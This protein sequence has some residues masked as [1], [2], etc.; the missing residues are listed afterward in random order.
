MR[1]ITAVIL[2]P[3]S[4]LALA[5]ALAAFGSS[6]GEEPAAGPDATR[7]PGDRRA[8]PAADRIAALVDG[9]PI[10]VDDVQGLVDEADGGVS[11][12]EALDALV[13]QQLLAAEAERRGFGAD[14]E[15][16]AERRKALARA[17]VELQADGVTVDTLDQEKLRKLYESSIDQFVHGPER[18]VI[19]AVALTGK[20]RLTDEEA[21]RLIG[22]V[23]DAARG[24][25][26]EERFRAAVR[27]LIA[28]RGKKVLKV[29]KLPPFHAASKRFAGPFVEAAFAVPGPGH[30]SEPFRTEFGW[31]VLLVLEEL[32]AADVSYEEAREIIGAEVVPAERKQRIDGLLDRLVE[33]GGVVVHEDSPIAEAGAQ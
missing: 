6:C 27:P 14:D 16:D 2:R 26:T 15:V 4:Q 10:T 12:A 1:T 28:E 7:R 21:R 22:Q 8:T 5:V 18:R 9:V 19:H 30:L 32:P 13:Q 31:H 29:E 23:R 25:T 20:Q 11:A 24:A 33:Q 17:L 3:T